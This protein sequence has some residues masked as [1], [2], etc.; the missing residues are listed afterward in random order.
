M[1]FSITFKITA[2]PEATVAKI[3]EEARRAGIELCGDGQQGTF[4]GFN[5]RGSYCREDNQIQVTVTEKP[6][7]VSETLIRKMA[8]EKAPE[9]GLAVA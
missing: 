5:A 9:W 4:S 1:A 3:M 7:F 6:F 2:E 8:L